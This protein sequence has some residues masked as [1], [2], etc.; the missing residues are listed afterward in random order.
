MR[1]ARPI[2]LDFGQ[3]SADH[4]PSSLVI[5]ISMTMARIEDDPTF[6]D[7][8]ILS[9]DWILSGGFPAADPARRSGKSGEIW[10]GRGDTS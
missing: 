1:L 5:D 3:F 7:G 6:S 9:G 4:W 8:R 10:I 2:Q